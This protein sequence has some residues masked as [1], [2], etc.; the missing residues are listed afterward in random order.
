MENAAAIGAACAAAAG[1][2][3]YCCS[4]G[5]APPDDSEAL[6]STL[7]WGSPQNHSFFFI[8]P[9]AH[10]EAVE[11]LV[12]ETLAASQIDVV[13]SGTI[14]AAA[15]DDGGLIDK[16]YGTLAERA[17]DVPPAELPV[18]SEAK[19]AEFEKL[20]GQSHTA[21]AAAG[22]LLNLRQAQA[23]LPTASP[24]EI[25]RQWRAGECLKLA[26]GTYVAKLSEAQVW[27]VNGFYASMRAKFTDAELNPAGIKWLQLRWDESALTWQAF[28]DDV[29]GATDCKAAREGSLRNLV[30]QRWEALGLQAAPTG[31]ENGV[32]ASASPLEAA[33]ERAIWLRAGGRYD[34]DP[35][36]EAWKAAGLP[37][38]MLTR[39]STNP[40]EVVAGKDAAN[41][42]DVVEG[43][44]TSELL[45]LALA[46]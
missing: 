3:W 39:W 27:V 19:A 24:K 4:S 26:P 10:N 1:A 5:S 7:H 44:D 34:G 20:A 28:R 29:V 33:A 13:S 46:S 9:H 23:L 15:I 31:S 2:A 12:R 22:Q 37:M 35:L 6:A 25:E 14:S 16:H 30:L 45:R 32:H 11:A 18:W 8:K 43:C 40:E 38:D 42:F 21:A 17:M 41:V 36:G